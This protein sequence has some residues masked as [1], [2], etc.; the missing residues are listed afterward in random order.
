MSK[1]TNPRSLRSLG[2]V[3]SS[4]FFL[5]K[6]QRGEK[7]RLKQRERALKEWIFMTNTK[8]SNSNLMRLLWLLSYASHVNGVRIK[9]LL[10]VYQHFVDLRITPKTEVRVPNDGWHMFRTIRVSTFPHY[11][12]RVITKQKHLLFQ[13]TSNRFD[14]LQPRV[15]LRTYSMT[16]ETWR[17]TG[18]RLSLKAVVMKHPNVRAAMTLREKANKEFALDR[19]VFILNISYSCR[20]N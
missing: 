17:P 8:H 18:T 9:H 4:T 3:K 15:M 7:S 6:R 2:P 19:T 1:V 16:L 12:S 5:L 20:K 14:K 13:H 11:Y 10:I